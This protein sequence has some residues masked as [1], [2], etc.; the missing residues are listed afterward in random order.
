MIPT[1]YHAP[2]HEGSRPMRGADEQPGSVFSD[3]SLEDRVPADP[4]LRAMR[5]VT[6]RAPSSAMSMNVTVS[7]AC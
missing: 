5:R 1:F 3:V 7:A 6:D 4:P 2:T